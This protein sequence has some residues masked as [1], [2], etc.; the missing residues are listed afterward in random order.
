MND[1]Y[2][3]NIGI[4]SGSEESGHGYNQHEW[5]FLTVPR[6]A[7]SA[8]AWCQQDNECQNYG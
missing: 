6:S 4:C 1:M 2:L 8:G 7:Y 3:P 5:T